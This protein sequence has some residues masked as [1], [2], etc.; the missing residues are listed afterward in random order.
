MDAWQADSTHIRSTQTA[1]TGRQYACQRVVQ[2]QAEPS[3]CVCA[4]TCV[5]V[6]PQEKHGS[7][8]AFLDGA[9]PERLCQPMVDY[10]KARGG[11][12]MMNA[13][14]KEIVLNVRPDTHTHTY[15]STHEHTRRRTLTQKD[16]CMHEIRCGCAR[17]SGS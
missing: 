1:H 17:A 7:K 16:A 5:C 12:L 8:M 9:P 14:V 15:T 13:R 10:F 11:D 2:D 3:S 6:C 4:C